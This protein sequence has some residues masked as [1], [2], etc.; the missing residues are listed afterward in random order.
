MIRKYLAQVVGCLLLAGCSQVQQAP[1]QQA[2]L[3]DALPETTTVHAEWAAP[4]GDSGEVD[5][6]WIASFNDEQ[7]NVLVT[8]A[9]STQN[10]QMRILSANVDRAEAST[11]LAASAKK[12]MVGVGAGLSGT[13]GNAAVEQNVATGGFGVSWEVDVWGRIQ[14]GVNA[15][16]ENLRATEADFQAG[17]MSLAAN[18]AK[19]WYLAT[20]L[21]LQVQLAEE[22]VGILEQTVS[23]VE[24]KQQIGQISMQDVFLAR[25]TLA[26]SRDALEAARG[27]QRQ[28]QRALE[29]LLGRYPAGEIETATELVPVPPPIPVGLP[30]DLL[31]RRPDLIAAERR[32]AAAFFVSEQARL[33]RLPSFS[34][35]GQGGVTSALSG[36]IGTLGAGM[37]APL[38]TG[39]AIEAQIDIAN[40]DQQAAIGAYGLAVLN[41]FEEVEAALTNSDLLERREQFLAEAVDNNLQV[42]N[43]AQKQYEVGQ[44]ELL[45]LLQ[46]QAGWIGARV[47]LLDIRN[48]RLAERINL[49]LALG[50]SFQ[51]ENAEQAPTPTGP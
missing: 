17:R 33:A 18:V 1:E 32:V 28:A 14:A 27:G 36:A 13:G 5:D 16:D 34:L 25:G 15:A 8:E 40:A 45:N 20:E 38:Y 11:R 35:T 10:P 19:A 48:Q 49:H 6:N 4:A 51:D 50:G 22:V 46:I 31:E 29:I 37:V 30:S 23:L 41:A 44:I 42:Y 39:G 2:V 12:P 26:S 24:K 21:S 7:L 47:G 3:E 9:I 43:L